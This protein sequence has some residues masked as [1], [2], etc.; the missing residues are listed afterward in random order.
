MSDLTAWTHPELRKAIGRRFEQWRESIGL[1][2][3]PNTG[4]WS[5]VQHSEWMALIESVYDEAAAELARL[6]QERVLLKEQQT[7]FGRLAKEQH[8]RDVERAE[9]AEAERDALQAR[10]DGQCV[11]S[12]A[13]EDAS[14]WESCCGKAWTI[15]TD[16]PS[17]NGL[18]FCM[19]CGKRVV[20][21]ASAGEGDQ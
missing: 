8:Q 18:T 3:N 21:T 16:G 5:R 9:Q 12:L 19:K 13:D 10:V 1:H 4:H 2:L 15:I 14:M 11:W 7:H 17:E 20:L 6:E